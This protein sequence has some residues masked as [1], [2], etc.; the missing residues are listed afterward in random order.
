MLQRSIAGGRIR[1]ILLK[2]SGRSWVLLV[3]PFGEVG[4]A[5][6]SMLG[7]QGQDQAKL[8]YE[9]WFGGGFERQ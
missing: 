1:R 8:F 9:F 2:K 3:L 5:A 6:T 7:Q 4:S